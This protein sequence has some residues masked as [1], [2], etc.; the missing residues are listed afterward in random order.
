[1]ERPHRMSHREAQSPTPIG[2]TNPA[3]ERLPFL[4]SK[5]FIGA[6]KRSLR[7]GITAALILEESAF[8]AEQKWHWTGIAA[9]GA[10]ASEVLWTW[11]LNK[12]RR[13]RE[14]GLRL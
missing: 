7:P 3:A 14:Q 2:D 9:A 1:M 12:E 11:Q 4:R 5:T 10:V 6:V 8:Y 13:E